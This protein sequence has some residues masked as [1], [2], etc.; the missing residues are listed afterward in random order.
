MSELGGA[1]IPKPQNEQDFE[2]CNVV[3]WRCILNDDNVKRHGRR[4]QRQHG[5]D[6]VG[7]REGLPNQIVGIQCKLKGE[8]RKLSE[9][10]VR[11]EVEKALTFEPPLCEYIIVTTAPDDTKLESLARQLS[12]S[13]SKHRCKDLIIN[14]FGWESL[15]QRIRHYPEAVNAFD[16]S[17]TPH[18]DRKEQRDKELPDEVAS[19]LLPQFD[20]IRNDIAALKTTGVEL[21][22]TGISTEY[23]QLIDTIRVFLPTNPA[24]ALN[25]LLKL[26]KRLDLKA[27]KHIRFRVASNIAACQ[28]ELG[29][30]AA[31]AGFIAAWELSPDDPAAIANK[32]FGFLLRNDWKSVKTFAESMLSENP[33]NAALAAYYIRSLKNAETIVDPIAQV[34]KAV[35]NTPQVAEAHVAWLI[36]RGAPGAWIDAAIAANNACPDSVE[37]EEVYACALLSR[38]IAGDR[39][40]QTHV[41]DDAALADVDK[42]I[43]IFES[44]WPDIRD[45]VVLRRGDPTSIVLNLMIAYR[46][47]GRNK[48]SIKTANEAP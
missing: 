36:D 13:V 25:L 15:Q 35:R 20:A 18:G 23:D 6:I 44:R 33:D 41:L 21:E 27:T 30:N 8:G 9:D 16:P 19:T 12:I 34:P 39:F 42:A 5:V 37:L 11:E 43:G 24:T 3:L 22:H 17:H 38:A 48:E 10:E 7:C 29:N 45:R 1:Q 32:A 40:V 26:Q 31:A 28:F 2:D 47:L 46:L 14:I 4:G